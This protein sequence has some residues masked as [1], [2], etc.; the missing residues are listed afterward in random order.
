MTGP[1]PHSNY[2]TMLR[3]ASPADRFMRA[4]ALSAYLR[5]LVWQGAVIHAGHQGADAVADRFLRQ[6]YGEDVA[7]SFRT[8]RDRG[9]IG[10]FLRGGHGLRDAELSMDEE[11]F[12]RI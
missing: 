3:D 9:T 5:A 7:R 8:V 4:M 6:L 1:A 2:A 10:L 12:I 11:W